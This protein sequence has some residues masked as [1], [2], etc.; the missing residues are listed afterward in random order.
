MLNHKD[1]RNRRTH[2]VTS[3]LES[4]NNFVDSVGGDVV[5]LNGAAAHRNG[6]SL[7]ELSSDDR[8]EVHAASRKALDEDGLT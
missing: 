5:E 4:L 2:L 6:I 8:S 3:G 1:T 7:I